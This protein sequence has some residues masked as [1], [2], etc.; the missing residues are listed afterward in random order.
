MKYGN[1]L[2][3]S[4]EKEIET[5]QKSLSDRIDRINDGLTDF[6]DCFMSDRCEQR[7]IQTNKEKIALIKDGGCAWF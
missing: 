3:K 5:L 4:L 7:G 6:D 2:I 1:E